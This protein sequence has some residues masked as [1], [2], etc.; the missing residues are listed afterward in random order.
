[1]CESHGI[2][3]KT[4]ATY[5]PR[6]NGAAERF[7]DILKRELD[8]VNTGRSPR[9][10]RQ[11]VFGSSPAAHDT[12]RS[13]GFGR[14]KRGNQKMECRSEL[15]EHQSPNSRTFLERKEEV[16]SPCKQQLELEVQQD[17]SRVQPAPYLSQSLRRSQHNRR[18]PFRYDPCSEL[19]SHS[20][21]RAPKRGS[22]P[23]SDRAAAR[24]RGRHIGLWDVSKQ[25]VSKLGR[26]KTGTLQNWDDSKP[27][28][29]KLGRFKTLSAIVRHG[30]RTSD[31]R[32]HAH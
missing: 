31:T 29:S 30:V 13:D 8:V 7:V 22:A 23:Y 1:M 26:F 24:S 15:N 27:A 14:V 25:D 32:T 20:E 12:S 4:T 9:G 11:G 18:A 16:S 21:D 28:T 19:Q 2:T 6:S 3:P 17:V 10:V 5:C